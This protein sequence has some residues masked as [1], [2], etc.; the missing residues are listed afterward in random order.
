MFVRPMTLAAAVSVGILVYLILTVLVFQRVHRMIG[1]TAGIRAA[2]PSRPL[3][4]GGRVNLGGRS[5]PLNAAITLAS[6]APTCWLVLT[7][8][9][10]IRRR[11]RERLDQ[12]LECGCPLTAKRGRCPRCGERYERNLAHEPRFP[13][14]A[15]RVLPVRRRPRAAG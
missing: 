15:V 1:V 12:C 6:I 2:P 13:V 10:T 14:H 11:N 7:T 8:L 9:S 4:S 3:V 5:M